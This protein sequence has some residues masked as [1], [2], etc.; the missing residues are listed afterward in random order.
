M[1]DVHHFWTEDIRRLKE[2]SL[3]GKDPD[4]FKQA[5]H[6]AYWLR[7]IGP[8]M[9]YVVANYGPLNEREKRSRDFLRQFNTEYI[10]FDVGYQICEFYETAA[11]PSG[12]VPRKFG[13]DDEYLASICCFLKEKNVS[14]H[15]L[16]LIYK[17][18]FYKRFAD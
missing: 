15:A 12:V 11:L 9:D 14:P 17:S 2:F 13:I 8:V 16:Y 7:R 5:A 18:L 4:H 3:A 1:A 6:L 10:A